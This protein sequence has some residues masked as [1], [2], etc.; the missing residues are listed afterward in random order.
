MIG[1]DVD[2]WRGLV[3]VRV[4]R[5]GLG[6]LESLG[7]LPAR[8]AGEPVEDLTYSHR[9]THTVDANWKT[10]TDNYGEGYH[11]PFVHPELNRQIDARKYRV[12]VQDRWV[13][14]HAPT[15]DGTPSASIT[16]SSTGPYWLRNSEK[17]G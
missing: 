12:D 3:F 15:R 16:Y 8:C 6:L 14:H 13:E 11:V 2:E 10:Y 5:N 17:R 9:V 4:N 7:G 1:L